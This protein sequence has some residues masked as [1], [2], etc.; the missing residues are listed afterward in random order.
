M[1]ASGNGSERPQQVVVVG[2]DGQPV[3][4]MPMPQD[5]DGDDGA[6]GRR[7]DGRAAGQGHA[8]RHDDQAAARGGPGGAPRRASRNRLRDIHAASIREL[9]QGLAPELREEL[10]RITLPFTEGETPDGRR[11]ADRPGPAGRLAGG[12]LPRH[13][14]GD[15]R[16][17]DG[18]PRTAGGDPPQGA[19]RRS[20]A[21]RPAAGL[22]S[23]R[24]PVPLTAGSASPGR[25]NA[26]LRGFATVARRP[27]SCARGRTT[28]VDRS[29]GTVTTEHYSTTP[30]TRTGQNG[31]AVASLVT[32][33]VG[34]V[35]AVLFAH[36][37]A[38]ARRGERRAGRRGPPQRHPE[39]PGHRRPGTRRRRD[40]RRRREHGD[41]LR[42]PDLSRTRDG[43]G[44][45]VGSGAV[46]VV[47]HGE[48]ADRL[49][50]LAAHPGQVAGGALGVGDAL[51]GLLRAGGETGDRRGDALRCRWPPRPRC[52]SSRSVVA[53]C[54]STA[55]AMVAWK[56]LISAITELIWLI[57]ST[58]PAVSVWIAS[59]RGGDVL[60]R[61]GGLLGQLLDLAGH[62]GEALAGLAGAG[63]LD[64]GVEGQQVG[65]LGDAVDQLDR[66]WRSPARS[67]RACR[68]SAWSSRRR[69]RPD[70]RRGRPRWRCARS[71]GSRT[72]SARSRRRRC[73]RWRRPRPP[74]RR[75]RRPA[76]GGPG[77]LACRRPPRSA[78]ARR[79]RAGST[80]RSQQQDVAE[81][82]ERVS[83]D[84]AISSS[85]PPPV[86]PARTVRSPSATWPRTSRIRCTGRVTLRA[87]RTPR[88][89]G[90][91]AADR[92]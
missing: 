59:T 39:R 29:G 48:P 87:T 10:E 40:R 5:D 76:G 66:P 82:V 71:R 16:P 51:V 60:G 33:I 13:P 70:R 2:P 55:A 7:R 54:S 35:F 20:A 50:Q 32:G 52:G 15:V 72:P 73:P 84:A 23:R 21:R 27:D 28:P 58:A 18:R 17:A 92:R 25:V 79:R 4:A 41:R 36:H 30:A 37:R 91:R 34:I 77:A 8:D 65:L 74:R 62:D 90:R 61:P 56:S 49:L 64:G 67:R 22:P 42:D 9:E 83:S 80:S 44:S 78:A 38:R 11:T 24:R 69:S 75:R 1:T 31:L 12:R 86:R 26:V 85:S 47:S 57:A 81:R 45:P 53:V 43:A 89:D 88:H 68:R 46:S 3:G 63:R 14:D 19:A 6:L